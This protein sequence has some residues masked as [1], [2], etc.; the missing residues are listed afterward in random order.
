MIFQEGQQAFSSILRAIGGMYAD[1]L[2]LSNLYEFLDYKVSLNRRTDG[3]YPGDYTVAICFWWVRSHMW[4]ARGSMDSVGGYYLHLFIM[5][6]VDLTSKKMWYLP[7]NYQIGVLVVV[8][9]DI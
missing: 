2:Y 5:E 9:L 4:E 7:T 8:Y 3:D 6:R 1:N